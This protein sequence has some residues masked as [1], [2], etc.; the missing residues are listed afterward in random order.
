[1]SGGNTKK[2]GREQLGGYFLIDDAKDL[3]EEI[4]TTPGSH[5]TQRHGSPSGRE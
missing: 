2:K 1:M 5:G 3:N 4:G